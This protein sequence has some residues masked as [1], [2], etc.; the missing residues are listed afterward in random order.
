MVT[1]AQ[2]NEVAEVFKSYMQTGEMGFEEAFTAAAESML[3][4][5]VTVALANTTQETAATI[6]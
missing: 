1:H 2:M 6:I 4:V 3:G 5:E